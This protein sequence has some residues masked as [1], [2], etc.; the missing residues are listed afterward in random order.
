MALL[1]LALSFVI[2]EE[3]QQGWGLGY[4]QL[5]LPSHNSHLGDIK[6][7]SCKSISSFEV[8]QIKINHWGKINVAQVQA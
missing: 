7:I 3:P 6:R 1:K 5:V 4:W 8:G 2:G